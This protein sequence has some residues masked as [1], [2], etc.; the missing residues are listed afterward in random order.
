MK[1]R[2]CVSI[3]IMAMSAYIYPQPAELHATYM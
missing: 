2:Q 3:L 1:T